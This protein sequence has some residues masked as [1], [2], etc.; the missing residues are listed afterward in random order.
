M[1]I[2]INKFK[3]GNERTHHAAHRTRMPY[4]TVYEDLQTQECH[5][6]FI[7]PPRHFSMYISFFFWQKLKWMHAAAQS[8]SWHRQNVSRSHPLRIA[9]QTKM[10]NGTANAF[11]CIRWSSSS[12]T[13]L[14]SH[15]Q[16]RSIPYN[17]AYTN[18]CSLY[19]FMQTISICSIN[20]TNAY[21]FLCK[22]FS[23]VPTTCEHLIYSWYMC[24]CV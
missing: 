13:E 20:Q 6:I 11:L 22:W 10:K 4:R 5:S 15:H 3:H 12:P 24:V 23:C 14:S 8:T 9:K 16:W 19:L 17:T 1:L 2:D 7:F 21:A 18:K